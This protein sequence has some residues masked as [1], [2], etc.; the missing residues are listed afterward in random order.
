MVG[1]INEMYTRKKDMFRKV[2]PLLPGKF[3]YENVSKGETCHTVTYLN[4]WIRQRDP[5]ALFWIIVQPFGSFILH[6][7]P[8]HIRP[9]MRNRWSQ[10]ELYTRKYDEKVGW[11]NIFS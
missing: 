5:V 9:L 7:C 2:R 1:T 6:Y 10:T 11:C 3:N 4:P 8:D